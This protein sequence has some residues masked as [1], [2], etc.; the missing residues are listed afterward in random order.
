VATRILEAVS[1][2]AVDAAIQAEERLTAADRD[3]RQ[4]LTHELAEARFDASLAARRYE[5][6]EPGKRLVAREL[7]ARWNAALSSPP[8]TE[9]TTVDG[10][11][12]SYA[13]QNQAKHGPAETG[14]LRN[15]EGSGVSGGK[16]A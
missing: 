7:E 9:T 14:L 11:V 13:K 3:V 2:L 8:W 4:A 16:S 12:H 6:V 1:P 15:S 5:A 10:T